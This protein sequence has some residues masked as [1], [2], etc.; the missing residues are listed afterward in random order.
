MVTAK[1]K[2]QRA[3]RACLAERKSTFACCLI[4]WGQGKAA[5]KEGQ[6][7]CPECG[8]PAELALSFVGTPCWAH[9]PERAKLAQGKER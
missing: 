5:Y 4:Q 1:E 8:A 9:K 3:V 2:F 7:V 6:P